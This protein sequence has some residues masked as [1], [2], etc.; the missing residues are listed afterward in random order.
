MNQPT[1]YVLTLQAEPG[2]WKT[3]PWQRL[4]GLLKIALRGFGLRCVSCKESAAQISEQ[5]KYK[6]MKGQG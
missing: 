6:N 2:A 4:R 1:I 3:Q 5:T